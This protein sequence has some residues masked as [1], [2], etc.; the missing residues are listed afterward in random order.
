MLTGPKVG[1]VFCSSVFVLREVIVP[2][3]IVI[4][5]SNDGYFLPPGAVETERHLLDFLNGVLD[6]SVQVSLDR[7]T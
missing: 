2:S 3:L 4:N 1:S 6:G 5:L 7:L